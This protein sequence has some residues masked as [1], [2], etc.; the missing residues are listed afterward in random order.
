MQIP[1]SVTKKRS[2]KLL[3]VN[4]SNLL[5][6]ILDSTKVNI[7]PIREYLNPKY[8]NWF[9]NSFVIE[10]TGS[11][12]NNG[13]TISFDEVPNENKVVSMV[14]NKY[15]LVEHRTI[16]NNI[17]NV[18][19]D[20]LISYS[21]P[22][23]YIDQKSGKNGL[24][25]TLTLDDLAID[26]D[27]SS[28]NPTIDIFNSTDGKSSAG[29][30]IGAYR[31]KCS[32]GMMIGITLKELTKLIHTP[33]IIEKFKFEEIFENIKREFTDFSNSI[34]TMQSKKITKEMFSFLKKSG[35]NAMF[36]K[37]YDK[38]LEKY[39]LDQNEVINKETL[40]GLYASATNFVSNYIMLKS[41]SLGI[42]HQRILTNMI[43]HFN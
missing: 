2:V 22:A 21:I 8:E 27:G 17:I 1:K 32:N 11:I 20:N 34:E 24:Y 31:S 9:E 43:N 41:H 36:I 28:I 39:M 10:R 12:I 25:A 23:I 42:L 16:L 6:Q 7:N 19:K 13:D 35:F 26:V 14:S 4:E 5:N 15:Q 18:L 33:S 29:L 38:I 30:I 3:N 40:W 37:H